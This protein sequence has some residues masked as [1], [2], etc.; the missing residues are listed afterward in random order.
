MQVESQTTVKLQDA[1]AYWPFTDGCMQEMWNEVRRQVK[2][3]LP[4]MP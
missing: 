4:K 3:D 2:D 1:N